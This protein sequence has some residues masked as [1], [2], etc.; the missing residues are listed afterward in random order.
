MALKLSSREK[1]CSVKS[2]GSVWGNLG[3]LG[4]GIL[5]LS[6]SVSRSVSV[7]VSV[8]LLKSKLQEV[9]VKM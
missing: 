9:K 3:H 8:S 2:E 6:V 5:H 1:A 7:S 4:G